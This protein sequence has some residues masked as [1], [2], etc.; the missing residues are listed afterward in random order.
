MNVKNVKSQMIFNRGE[1]SKALKK[2]LEKFL[3]INAHDA[4]N[5]DQS[6]KKPTLYKWSRCGPFTRAYECFIVS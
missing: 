1:W 5:K 2:F 4:E 6:N 3:A